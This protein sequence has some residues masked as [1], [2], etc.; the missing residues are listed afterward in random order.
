MFP[1]DYADPRRRATAKVC[2]I[3]GT[4]FFFPHTTQINA[5]GHQRKSARSAGPFFR[6]PQKTQ[7][8]AEGMDARPYGLSV[9]K[10]FLCHFSL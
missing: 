3:C 9:F 2:E 1:A 7:I 5:E 6:F 8:H 4:F 10:Y